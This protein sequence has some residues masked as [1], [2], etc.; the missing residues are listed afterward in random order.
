ML[1]QFDL[2]LFGLLVTTLVE[3]N[4]WIKWEVVINRISWGWFTLTLIPLYLCWYWNS[5]LSHR[6]IPVVSEGTVETQKF[7]TIG[8]VNKMLLITYLYTYLGFTKFSFQKAVFQNSATEAAA[9]ASCKV[10]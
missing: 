2:Q 9:A 4:I 1:L 10:I 5:N 8:A 3:Q 7:V 6:A